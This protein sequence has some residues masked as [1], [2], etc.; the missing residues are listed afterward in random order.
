MTDQLLNM[1]IWSEWM[2][3]GGIGALL[4]IAIE[5]NATYQAFNDNL[6]ANTRANQELLNLHREW[7]AYRQEQDRAVPN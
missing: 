4:M 1:A 5:I 6:I 2:K 3:V 7:F